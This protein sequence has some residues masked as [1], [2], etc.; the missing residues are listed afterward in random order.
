MGKGGRGNTGSCSTG[1]REARVRA[2]FLNRFEGSGVGRMEMIR[3]SLA[4][5]AIEESVISDDP[6]KGL[7]PRVLE[8]GVTTAGLA[9]SGAPP[10]DPDGLAEECCT[11]DEGNWKCSDP[12]CFPLESL[13][14][15]EAGRPWGLDDGGVLLDPTVGGRA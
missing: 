2:P 6:S 9:V 13:P 14:T 7:L 11:E 12:N 5:G 10:T 8:L 3:G 15:I 4:V 1:T